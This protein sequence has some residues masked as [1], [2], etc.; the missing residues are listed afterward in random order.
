MHM[1]H[2]KTLEILE[3]NGRFKAIL[4]DAGHVIGETVFF[5]SFA[6]AEQA[7]RNALGLEPEIVPEAAPE[8]PV[9]AAVAPV[10][11]SSTPEA[12]PAPEATPEAA[13]EAAPVEGPGPEAIGGQE[14]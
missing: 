10:E 9:E 7:G 14:A 13:P 1:N 12:A 5:G 3:D 8:A 2:D 11:A 4:K 6:E